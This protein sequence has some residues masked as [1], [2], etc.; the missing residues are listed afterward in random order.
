MQH[1]NKKHKNWEHELDAK[2]DNTKE[3]TKAQQ[4]IDSARYI[5]GRQSGEYGEQVC[6]RRGNRAESWAEQ[7]QVKTQT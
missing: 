6:K 2:R 3:K 5:Y 4:T 1:R 7:A